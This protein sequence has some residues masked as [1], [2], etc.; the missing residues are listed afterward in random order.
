MP[1]IDRQILLYPATAYLESMASRAENASGYFLTA[2]DLVWFVD[3]YV[4]D[5]LDAHNPLAF[6]LQTHDLSELPP[7]FVLTCGFDPLRD[8]GIEYANRLRNAGVDVEHTN[9][10][11]MIHGFLNMEGI[12]DRTHDG[13]EEIA[14]YLQRELAR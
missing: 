2:Q 4:E 11:S 5:T 9:Y 10:E 7:A 8:E 14:A 1:D 13:I 6:P 3:H 12:V